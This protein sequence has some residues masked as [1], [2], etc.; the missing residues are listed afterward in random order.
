M[1]K[2]V[3]LAV[4]ALFLGACGGGKSPEMKRLENEQK[5]L[6]LQSKLNDLQMQLVKEQ[7]TNEKLKQE[8]ES[9]NSRANSSASA[10]SDAGTA[11]ASAA[12]LAVASAAAF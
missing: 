11:S 1:K 5:A 7:A 8:A 2:L 12:A 4:T 9:I 10:F 6:S 3:V